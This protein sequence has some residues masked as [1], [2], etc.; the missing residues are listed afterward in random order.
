MLV[1]SRGI[2]LNN[3]WSQWSQV[4]VRGWGGKRSQCS[5]RLFIQERSELNKQSRTNPDNEVYR[6]SQ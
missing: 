6:E 1:K 5:V 2:L 3:K 4:W